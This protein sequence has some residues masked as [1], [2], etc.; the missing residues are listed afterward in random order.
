MKKQFL[1][2]L[3]FFT[4]INLFCQTINEVLII[5]IA[6][7]WPDALQVAHTPVRKLV[8]ITTTR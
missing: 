7:V 4:P 2:F 5:G 6:G 8:K 1:P 3:F